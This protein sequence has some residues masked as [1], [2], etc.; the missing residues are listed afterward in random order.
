[1]WPADDD[2]VGSR[3]R[4]TKAREETCMRTCVECDAG[5]YVSELHMTCSRCMWRAAKT[6]LHVCVSPSHARSAPGWFDSSM[7]P[8]LASGTIPCWTGEIMHI[9]LPDARWS[10]SMWNN[11]CDE[12]CISV[13]GAAQQQQVAGRATANMVSFRTSPMC[14]P[15]SRHRRVA[16][17]GSLISS[18]RPPSWCATHGTL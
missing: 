17:G 11:C 2:G 1:M 18:Q 16:P 7:K 3:L 12:H 10:V 6:H 8:T 15:C 9:A 14:I 13:P 5:S 4:W